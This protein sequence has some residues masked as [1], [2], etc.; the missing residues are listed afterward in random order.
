MRAALRHPFLSSRCFHNRLEPS[1]SRESYSPLA[2]VFLGMGFVL[3]VLLLSSAMASAQTGTPAETAAVEVLRVPPSGPT[4][5]PFPMTAAAT[6]SLPQTAI[7]SPTASASTPSSTAQPGDTPTATLDAPP[8][9]L[10]TPGPTVPI[11]PYPVASPTFPSGPTA[12]LQPTPTLLTATPAPTLRPGGGPSTPPW[13]TGSR[14]I[15]PT[16][17]RRSG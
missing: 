8:P 13:A 11:A 5:S 16:T 2:R 4:A 14:A 6:A 12:T 15:M 9:T 1:M 3:T 10:A 17:R 7:P